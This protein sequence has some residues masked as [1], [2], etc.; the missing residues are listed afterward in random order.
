[1]V[2]ANN[3]QGQFS[4]QGNFNGP[5]CDGG[6]HGDFRFVLRTPT[7]RA[8]SRFEIADFRFKKL[9]PRG[10]QCMQPLQLGTPSTHSTGSGQVGTKH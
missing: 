7:L 4:C 9:E 2:G 8:G 5:L 1:M 10:K 3:A 6:G